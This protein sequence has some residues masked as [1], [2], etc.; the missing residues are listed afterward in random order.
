MAGSSSG[1]EQ[2]II[3]RSLAYLRNIRVQCE[4]LSALNGVSLSVRNKEVVG[5][6]GENGSGKTTLVNVLLGM[7]PLESGEVYFEGRRIDM[8]SPRWAQQ[9]GIQTVPQEPDLIETLSGVRNFFLGQELRTPIGPIGYLDRRAMERTAREA[10]LGLGFPFRASLRRPVRL[11]SRR[12]RQ[13]IAISRAR[14]FARKL[15]I[16]DEPT[17]YLSEAEVDIVL[18]M[19]RQA[20][21]EGLSVLFL[22]CKAQEVFSV[23][24]RFVILHRGHNYSEKN[25]RH[26]N[27]RELE[28][29]LVTSR[30]TAVRQMAAAVAHQI[31]NPLGILRSSAE[32]LHSDFVVP[33]EQRPTYLHLTEVLVDEINTL[34]LVVDNFLSF[35]RQKRPNR[36]FCS[37]S[38]LVHASLAAIPMERFPGRE[39]K[40]EIQEDLPEYPL[41]RGMMEQV[42]SN[43]VVNA[44]QA[45]VENSCVEIRAFL[46]NSHLA[47]AVEDH[48]AGMDEQTLK[49]IFNP[50]FSTKASGSGLGLSIVQRIVEQH[51]GNI[52]V[53]S[54]PGRGTVFTVEL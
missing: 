13:I 49:Q 53:S 9:T 5:L 2:Q 3:D 39:V 24:D 16:L 34:N 19:V 50:F 15:L 29:L 23:A 6:L 18:T 31:R 14:Y 38:Q 47:I 21:H 26:T 11:L 40:V 25:K 7:I 45:S 44:L 42:V 20:R 30:F 48:G 27:Y 10:I 37:I 54:A 22:T 52:E 12:E 43:L 1:R 41:D 17:L 35:T 51:D 36:D 8:R 32:M 33:E 46:R 4:A 28:K